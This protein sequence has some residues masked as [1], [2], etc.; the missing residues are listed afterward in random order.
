MQK[1]FYPNSELDLDSVLSDLR[2][3]FAVNS[4]EIQVFRVGPGT[5]LQ[6]KKESTLTNLSG[7]SSA[8]TVQ[9]TPEGAGTW[10]EVGIGKWLEKAAVGVVGYAISWPLMITSALGFYNTHKLSEEVWRVITAN[11]ARRRSASRPPSNPHSN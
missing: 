8:L 9:I 5:V 11:V 7:L 10:V 3:Y 6:A 4:H 1:R 2:E